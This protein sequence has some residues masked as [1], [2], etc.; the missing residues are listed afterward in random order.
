MTKNELLNQ[1][2]ARQIYEKFYGSGFSNVKNISSPFSEDKNASF[3]IYENDTFKCYSTGKQG[4]VFQFVADLNQLDCKSNF[5]EVLEIISKAFSLNGFKNSPS[6]VQKNIKIEPKKEKNEIDKSEFFKYSPKD[7]EQ[8][9]FDYFNQGNW[10]VSPGVLKE[11]KVQALDKF[12]FW[13]SKKNEVS[14]IKLF[15]NVLGFIYSVNSNVELYI[16]QQEKTKKFFYNN[17]YREDIFG[18]EQLKRYENLDYLIICAG[19]K[20]CLILNSNEFPAVTFRSENHFLTENQAKQLKEI[21]SKI[22]VCFDNDIAGINAAKELNRKYGYSIIELTGNINDVADFFKEKT[23]KEFE[24][25]IRETKPTAPEP[26]K[27]IPQGN[28]IFHVV[29]NYLSQRYDFRFNTILLD[30]EYKT[31]G[32]E[33]W[34]ICNEDTLYVEMQKRNINISMNK[35]ISILK[36]DFVPKFNPVQEY[37]KDLPEWDKIDHI[38]KLCTYISSPDIEQFEYHLKKWL[39]R[40]VKCMLVDG[41]FN[42]QAFILTD[43]G[44]GQNIGKSHFTKWLT[45]PNLP[46]SRSFEDSKKDN[47]AKLATNTFIILD[48]LDGISKRDINALKA[49]FSYDEIRV[50]LPYDRREKTVQR[51]ANFIGSTNEENFLV[52]PTGSVRW[53]VFHVTHINWNYTKFIDI[54]KVWAQAFYLANDTVFD[55]SFTSQDVKNNEE[56]NEQYQVLSQEAELLNKHF[57]REE[58]FPNRKAVFMTTTDIL[59][60]L[61]ANSNLRI[62]N[63]ALGRALKL[64]KF[65]RCKHKGVYGYFVISEINQAY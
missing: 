5:Y 6:I 38:K 37:F 11:Y 46:V 45:I 36:S 32:S 2:P 55:E 47:L 44:E 57:K 39:A 51:I 52:D 59:I 58:D 10:N 7:F 19:K 30:I 21:T 43:K 28:T 26:Q 35:L 49:L 16:P 18:L 29:E 13:N 65:N 42:K 4:D 50:R 34:E 8:M 56:R 64:L 12:E 15:P 3:R 63:I 60:V 31:K 22:Y 24:S 41:Y 14:K 61:K 33:T 9:H 23:K 40:S 17:L 1:V 62:N 54:H 25:L 53:L 27:E 48:E 20:D